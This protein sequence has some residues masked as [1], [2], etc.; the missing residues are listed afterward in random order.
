MGKRRGSNEGSIYKRKDGRWAAS[1]SLRTGKRRTFYGKTRQEAAQKLLRAH[2]ALADGLP[3]A[4]ERT[5][6][7]QVLDRW[8]EDVASYKVRARTLRRYQ[9]IVRLHLVPAIGQ[10]SLSR[11][12]PDHIERMMNEALSRGQSP[13][14][15]AHSR[16]VLRTAL[17]T[18]M[19]WGLV[20]RNVA[21]LAEPP[22]IPERE[23]NP[24]TS[25]ESRRLLDAVHGDRLGALFTVA[26]ACGLRQSESLGLRW[27][28]VDLEEP[29]LRVQRTLQRVEGAFQFFEPKTKRSRRTLALPGPVTVALRRHRARQSEERLRAGSSWEGEAWGHLVFPDELGRPLSTYHIRRRFHQLLGLAGLPLMRYHDL[30]H[31]AAS[32]MA[33]QG[34]PPRVAMEILGHSQISTTM[35]IYT[36]VA[37]EMLHEAAEL[38]AGSLWPNS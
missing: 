1:I 16:A 25:T 18:A 34:V 19:R 32:L 6:V 28:D 37:Q 10:I 17:N 3:L 35:N 5:T 8:L 27:G 38:M 2:R 33:A 20:G 13:Q 24:L 36:H 4:Q 12:T 30:R 11:I 21:S 15:V 14:S 7:R 26:L 29:T 9:E 22:R 31:G 23:V